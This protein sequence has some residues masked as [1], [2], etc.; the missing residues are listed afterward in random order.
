MGFFDPI[1]KPFE[2][3]IDRPLDPLGVFSDDD[4]D[5]K[6]EKKVSES[7]SAKAVENKVQG[8]E[9]ENTNSLGNESEAELE[10]SLFDDEPEIVA[11][12]DTLRAEEQIEN[13]DGTTSSVVTETVTK[14][15]E[16][17]NKGVTSYDVESTENVVEEVK[18]GA[19]SKEEDKKEA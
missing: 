11:T 13:S 16:T 2:K 5:E 14:T 7:D 9:L 3:I 6:D 15:T 17:V 18:L 1:T 10:F 4:D 19:S 8:E 12:E